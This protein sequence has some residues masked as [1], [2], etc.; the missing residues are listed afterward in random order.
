MDYFQ[1][2]TFEVKIG[3]T[4]STPRDIGASIPQGGVLSSTLLSLFVNDLPVKTDPYSR[5]FSFLFADDI[6][7]LISS[8]EIT[9]EQKQI[10]KF[11]NELVKYMDD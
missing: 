3:N 9:N 11:L 1:E 2:R 5:E 7:Y 4:P 10:Q 6:S 8:K